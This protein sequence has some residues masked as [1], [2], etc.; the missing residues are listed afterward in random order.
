MK[1]ADMCCQLHESASQRFWER[2]PTDNEGSTE[3][4]AE[5]WLVSLSNKGKAKKQFYRLCE[6]RLLCYEVDG[7]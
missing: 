2:K 3:S 7:I 1:L 4:S 5:G 6:G